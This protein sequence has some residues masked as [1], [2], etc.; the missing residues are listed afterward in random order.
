MT[1]QFSHSPEM[2][3]AMSHSG[4]EQVSLLG[5]GGKACK[6]MFDVTTHRG[7]NVAHAVFFVKTREALC[8]VQTGD[9]SKASAS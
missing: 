8:S 9:K 6:H 5:F 3:M 4:N 2:Q 1:I 7:P